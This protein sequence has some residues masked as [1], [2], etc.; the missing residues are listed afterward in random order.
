MWDS[1]SCQWDILQNLKINI[2]IKFTLAVDVMGLI[3]H[4]TQMTKQEFINQIETFIATVGKDPTWFGRMAVND[5]HFVHD[6]KQHRNPTL[7]LVEKCQVFM[8]NYGKE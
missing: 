1:S 2:A 8:R 6:I 4:Y 7:R 3:P 5:S